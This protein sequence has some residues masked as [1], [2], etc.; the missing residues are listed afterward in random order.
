MLPAMWIWLAMFDIKVHVLHGRS[1][2]PLRGPILIPII[3]AIVGITVAGFF[4]NAVF[5]FAISDPVLRRSVRRSRR[6]V[7]T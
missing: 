5:A 1:F 6:P 7:V 2:N 3:L 4:L